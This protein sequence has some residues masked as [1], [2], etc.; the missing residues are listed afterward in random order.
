MNLDEMIKYIIWIIFIG[1]ALVGLYF[2]LK[3][4]GV[5]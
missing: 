3:K 4:T 2:L 1:I 5:I